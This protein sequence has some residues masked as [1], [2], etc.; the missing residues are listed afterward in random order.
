MPP[1][2]TLFTVCNSDR[3]SSQDSATE[4]AANGGNKRMN[5]TPTA[6]NAMDG[7]EAQKVVELGVDYLRLTLS[8]MA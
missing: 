3:G 6:I 2:L 1:R 7:N 8:Q 5:E 4:A